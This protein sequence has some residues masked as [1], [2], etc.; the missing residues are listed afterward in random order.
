MTMTD[1][2]CFSNCN[3]LFQHVL[4]FQKL[5]ECSAKVIYTTEDG[6]IEGFEFRCDTAIKEASLVKI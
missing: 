4:I 1:V 6:A 2:V 5:M 3:A